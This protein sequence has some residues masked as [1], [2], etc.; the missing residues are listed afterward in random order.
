MTIR[1]KEAEFWKGRFSLLTQTCERGEVMALNGPIPILCIML[2]R[3]EAAR[4]TF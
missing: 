2:V 1:T 3:H 4:F